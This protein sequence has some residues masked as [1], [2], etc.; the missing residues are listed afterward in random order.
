MNPTTTV[1]A[2]VPLPT[3]TS[4]ATMPLATITPRRPSGLRPGLLLTVAAMATVLLGL[5]PNLNAGKIG[6]AAGGEWCCS[7]S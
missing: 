1:T 5:G 2:I 7:A 6:V 3:T 4:T